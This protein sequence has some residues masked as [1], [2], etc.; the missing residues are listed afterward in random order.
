[1]I[2]KETFPPNSIRKDRNVK[3]AGKCTETERITD[4]Q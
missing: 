2:L 4:P 3:K 1:M